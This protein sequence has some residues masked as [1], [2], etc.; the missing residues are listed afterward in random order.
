MTDVTQR[1]NHLLR[2]YILLDRPSVWYLIVH[3]KL[4]H[5]RSSFLF[6]TQ[7][8]GSVTTNLTLGIHTTVAPT[9]RHPEHLV[10][11]GQ[12]QQ[13][14]ST[15]THKWRR[16]LRVITAVRIS[17]GMIHTNRGKGNPCAWWSI[18]PSKKVVGF[19]NVVSFFKYFLLN[20]SILSRKFAIDRLLS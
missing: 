19:Q 20:L 3:L 13:I 9:S 2:T 5:I 15:Y 8:V 12:N 14:F 11:P 4:P 16:S 18:R 6:Y 10:Y 1:G 7:S 17:L